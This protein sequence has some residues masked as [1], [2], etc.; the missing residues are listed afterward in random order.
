[1]NRPNIGDRVVILSSGEHG[2]LERDRFS[3]YIDVRKFCGRE[4]EGYVGSLESCLRWDE[5]QLES[6][7]LDDVHEFTYRKCFHDQGGE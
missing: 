5:V 3:G 7:W 4:H 1:M 2:V 6:E